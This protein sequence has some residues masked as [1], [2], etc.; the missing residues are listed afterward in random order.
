MKSITLVHDLIY[1]EYSNCKC[2]TCKYELR[3]A[4]AMVRVRNIPIY[5][6]IHSVG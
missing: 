4:T 1:S 6:I 3:S 5:T 2:S